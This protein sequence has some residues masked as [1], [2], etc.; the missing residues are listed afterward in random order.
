M[1]EKNTAKSVDSWMLILFVALSGT[2]A[3]A[4]PTPMATDALPQ[5]WPS[6]EAAASVLYP[7]QGEVTTDELRVR[8]GGSENYYICGEL[9]RGAK[10]VVHE[11][12]YGWLKIDP[13]TGFF[14]LIAADYVQPV[15]DS[16]QGVITGSVVRVRA[17]AH[18]S[19]D[20]YAVQCKLNKQDKVEIIGTLDLTLEGKTTSFYK[21][22]PPEGKAFLWVSAQYVRYLGPVGH[23]SIPL[24]VVDT[25]PAVVPESGQSDELGKLDE[26]LNIEMERPIADRRLAE[27]QANYVAL[28]PDIESTELLAHI[29]KRIEE[30]QQ[31]MIIQNDL[32]KTELLSGTFIQDDQRLRDLLDRH[33]TAPSTEGKRLREAVGMLKASHVFE[34][35]G[36]K[37]WRLVKPDSS[38]NICYLLPGEVSAVEIAS[39]EGKVVTVSGPAVFDLRTYLDLVV[40]NKIKLGDNT[41]EAK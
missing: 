2:I 13:P 9:T 25:P 27:L 36:L 18:K 1:S 29:D 15:A 17:G 38:E 37:R 30:I 19:K 6:G 4:Q 16:A 22:V 28:R 39:K 24:P 8:A 32:A 26:A 33:G 10:I 34:G 35:P 7:A 31:Q 14:S 12:R 41:A 3:Y 20:N 11:N 23:S 21:I 5:S 40:V